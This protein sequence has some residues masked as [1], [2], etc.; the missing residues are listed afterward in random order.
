VTLTLTVLAG[1][2]LGVVHVA[3]LPWNVRLYLAGPR[4]RAIAL[5]VVRFAAV[6]AVMWLAGRHGVGALLA[7]AVGF[8]AATWVAA[9]AGVR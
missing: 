6:A 1:L 4:D 7:L 9:R 2:A 8:L 3:A 5:H